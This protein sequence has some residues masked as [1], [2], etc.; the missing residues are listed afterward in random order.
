M[1]VFAQTTLEPIVRP[2]YQW[3]SDWMLPVFLFTLVA[4]AY[5][6]KNYPFRIQRLWTST[7]NIRALRQAIREEPNTPRANLLFNVN[8]ALLMGL[9]LYLTLGI[10]AVPFGG[11]PSFVVY[12]ICIG[13]VLAA[14]FIKQ[15]IINTVKFL[16][17]GD[18][19]LTEYA[20]NVNLINRVIGLFLFPTL[21]LLVYMP[22][23]QSF[24]YWYV[25]AILVGCML[26]YR[27]VRGIINALQVNVPLFYIFFYICTL[28][29][30]PWVVCARL[31]WT[32]HS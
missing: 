4:I 22:K 23:S 9:F 29:I 26:L 14:Y 2:A 7:W 5:T 15:L 8:H 21:T 3:A 20:Y 6:R 18:F 27:I 12:L 25:A 1:V 30:L 16:G 32:A 17:D 19:G 24:I 28:E 11:I 10:W 31:I 13:G